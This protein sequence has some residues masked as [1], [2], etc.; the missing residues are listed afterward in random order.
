MARVFRAVPGGRVKRMTNRFSSDTPHP[1]FGKKE[2]NAL[3][4]ALRQKA[5]DDD[6]GIA[7]DDAGMKGM[8]AVSLVRS[9]A[10]PRVVHD[11][12]DGLWE[13]GSSFDEMIWDSVTEGAPQSGNGG[14]GIYEPSL[15]RSRKPFRP[16]PVLIHVIDE[17]IRVAR[18]SIG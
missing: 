5:D 14:G 7:V 9:F 12:C 17:A 1:D 11:D 8:R 18:Q 4:R 10:S 13:I 15:V 2:L 6:F 3:R 16:N